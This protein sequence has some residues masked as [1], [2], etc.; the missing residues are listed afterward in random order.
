MS[1][2]NVYKEPLSLRQQEAL[3]G[4]DGEEGNDV[5]IFQFKI[6]FKR[7]QDGQ[8]EPSL[9]LSNIFICYCI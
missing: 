4:V 2:N 5:F 7:T 1:T 6:I 8:K 3:I 9:T